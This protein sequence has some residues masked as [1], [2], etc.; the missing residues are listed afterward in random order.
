MAG[1]GLGA[2]GRPGRP[3][4]GDPRGKEDPE[5]A[6]VKPLLRSRFVAIPTEAV[7]VTRMPRG[8]EIA[9]SR[10]KEVAGRHAAGLVEDGMTVG[11]GTGSTVHY[12]LLELGQ[13]VRDE[14]LSI[15][16]VPTSV[17]TEVKARELSIPLIGLEEV[18]R[19]DLTIDGA[20]EIDP[21]FRMIKG[22]GGA[23]LREKVVA[24]MSARE[25]IVV[26]RSKVVE[27]LGVRFL[28]PVEVVPFA[29]PVVARRLGEMGAIPT[30]RMNEGG[31]PFLTDNQNEILDCRFEGGIADPEDLERRLN[32]LPGVVENGLFV[33]LAHV[34]VIGDAEGNVEV[35][36]L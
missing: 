34:L 27:R 16:G 19:I 6:E 30:M 32:S 23:L 22:G 14:K 10:A 7:R 8:G 2:S 13:R 29:R 4:A 28:L 31:T 9:L 35:R 5:T 11:L 24:S 33:G 15:R 26:D 21:G 18:K 12:A 25:A 3:S 17:D 1:E 36:T 20:D